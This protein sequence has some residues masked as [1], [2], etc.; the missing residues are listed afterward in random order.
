MLLS[1]SIM[2]WWMNIKTPI[3]FKRPSFWLSSQTERVSLSETYALKYW[4]CSPSRT[5]IA[6]VRP[7]VWTARG[8][9]VCTENLILVAGSVHTRSPTTDEFQFNREDIH[10]NFYR[11]T[12]ACIDAGRRG[13]R[14]ATGAVPPGGGGGAG[15]RARRN[16]RRQDLGHSD[17]A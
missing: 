14:R 3:G 6:T 7:T 12:L 2:S 9:G 1:G 10:E 13:G 11:W 4:W 17:P 16:P 5:G 15:R 8:I